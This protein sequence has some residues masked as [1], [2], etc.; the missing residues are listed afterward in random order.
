MS[1]KEKKVAAPQESRVD[2]KVPSN[3]K[4]YRTGFK[5]PRC[6]NE[7]KRS[8]RGKSAKHRINCRFCSEAITVHIYHRS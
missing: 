3:F 7:I 2:V 8:L 1:A 5:C 4:S 6:Q